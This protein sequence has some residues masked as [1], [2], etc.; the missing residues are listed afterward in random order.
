M[1]FLRQEIATRKKMQDSN[2][3]LPISSELKSKIF[4][5]SNELNI[6]MAELARRILTDA[7]EK[8]HEAMR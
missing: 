4:D 6:G 5:K 3:N 7:F 1:P 2:L 8:P